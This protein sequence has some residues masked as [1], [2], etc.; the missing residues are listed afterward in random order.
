M[1]DRGNEVEQAERATSEHVVDVYLSLIGC[2]LIIVAAHPT[3]G[4]GYG[5]HHA[6]LF[7][8][9]FHVLQNIFHRH[10]AK[11]PYEGLV[12]HHFKGHLVGCLDQD[13][14]QAQFAQLNKFRDLGLDFGLL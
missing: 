5:I 12:H 14:S 4:D 13:L 11:H 8:L 2:Q 3:E 10:M 7:H 1:R 6:R 9:F